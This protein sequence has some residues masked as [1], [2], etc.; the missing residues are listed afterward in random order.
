MPIHLTDEQS[1]AAFAARLAERLHPPCLIFLE[2]QLG[3]GKTSFARG[4]IRAKGYHGVVRSP[5]YTLMEVYPLAGCTI[6]HLDLYRLGNVT[7]LE[8]LGVRDFLSRDTYCLVE[9][10]ERAS[11][12]LG[13]PDFLLSFSYAEPG[14]NVQLIPEM[15][16]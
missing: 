1:T 2:G 16:L 15:D 12:H 8:E 13:R 6:I 5:T 10:P 7:E 3:A 14:R 4:F 11:G 9:W